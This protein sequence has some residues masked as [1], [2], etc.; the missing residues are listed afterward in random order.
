V[1]LGGDIAI[2]LLIIL[3]GQFEGQNVVLLNFHSIRFRIL[4]L[5]DRESSITPQYYAS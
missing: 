4:K 3:G 1:E 5:S 2:P